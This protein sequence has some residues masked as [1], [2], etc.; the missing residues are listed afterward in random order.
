[1]RLKLEHLRHPFRTAVAAKERVAARLNMKR[2]ADSGERRFRGDPRYALESVTAGFASRLAPMP[3]DEQRRGAE[4][5]DA[6]LLQRI[7][8]AY[9]KAAEDEE[10][11]SPTYRATAWWERIRQH[12]LKP[13]IH[14]LLNRHL[15]AL[16]RMYGNFFRDP[17]SAGLIGMPWSGALFGDASQDVYRRF[18][19]SDAL[20]RIDYWKAQTEG[21]FELSELAG[22]ESGN[23]FGVLIDGT[24]IRLGSEY[25]HYCA[26]RIIDFL[27]DSLTALPNPARAT[28]AEIGGGFGDMAYYLLRDQPRIAYLDFD[29]PETIALASYYLLKS[30]PERRFLLYGEGEIAADTDVVLMPAFKLVALPAASADVAFCSHLLS[31]ISPQAAAEYLEAI[32]RITRDRFL[33]VGSGNAAEQAFDLLRRGDHRFVLAATR[34]SEWHKHRAPRWDEVECVYRAVSQ[35]DAQIE[36]AGMRES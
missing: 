17:C 21:R 33:F 2:C 27:G 8:S 11:V 29:L 6:A 15:D 30:F 24:L 34:R 28:V 4:P 14:A 36:P 22:P 13:V 32:A 5:D 10:S 12:N 9:I 20:H 25:H 1:M 19:L 35:S 16:R 3:E 31:D 7:C 26:Q 23:P 18:Y